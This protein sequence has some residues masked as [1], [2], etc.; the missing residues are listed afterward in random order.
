MWGD[1]PFI[2][3]S[4]GELIKLFCSQNFFKDKK[5]RRCPFF[6]ER[7]PVVWLCLIVWRV[8]ELISLC[9]CSRL[10]KKTAKR[11]ENFCSLI[12]TSISCVERK[13]EKLLRYSL[14]A[15]ASLWDFKITL[16]LP[17]P[18]AILQ[19][20]ANIAQKSVFRR[21]APYRRGIDSS[22]DFF[23]VVVR[24]RFLLRLVTNR[25]TLKH[26]QVWHVCGNWRVFSLYLILQLD[27]M[28][29]GL[30]LGWR[31]GALFQGVGGFYNP[32]MALWCAIQPSHA[33]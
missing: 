33:L 19:L 5:R 28:C 18:M 21:K 23:N 12:L 10:S 26:K 31:K 13:P 29:D 32:P 16:L 20:Y 3:Q 22:L 1:A 7:Q 4:S 6:H 17:T 30:V 11:C 8:G 15:V 24:W 27:H 25:L 14:F 2:A 9:T